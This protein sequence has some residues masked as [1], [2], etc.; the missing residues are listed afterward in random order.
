MRK[1]LDA[2]ENRREIA[3]QPSA[4][5]QPRQAKCPAAT[6]ATVSGARI[7]RDNWEVRK[8]DADPA[9]VRGDEPATATVDAV[10]GKARAKKILKPGNQPENSY[11]TDAAMR[12]VRSTMIGP[13]SC[14]E[15]M[16]R[17]GSAVLV[18]G[19]AF[20]K[21][22]TLLVA[23]GTS[24][25]SARLAIDDI[26]KAYKKAAGNEPVLLA[27]TS[28]IIR[29]KLAKE[30][31]PVL[32][33]NAAMNE[34]AAQG[35]TDLKIQ[36]LHIAPAEE[37]NQLE[38]MVV[39]NIT[40]N[41]GVFKTVKVGYP[42]L[43]SEKDLDAV[44]KVVLASLPKDRKPGDAVVLMGHGNDRGPGDLT[45]A[46]TAAAFHKADPHVWLATVE[47][48]N[49]FDNVLPKLKASGAKRVWLQP[50]MIVAGDHANNDLAGPE[51][52]SWASRIKAAG[53]TPMPNLK[54]LGQLKG[55][56]DIFL[57]HTQNAVVDLANTKKAD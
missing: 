2:P 18:A 31:K 17:H 48:S 22:G 30:G 32:S 12:S 7:F 53:M 14:H 11:G 27:F 51:E 19:T 1:R 26:E 5:N 54:G 55:I 38:R 24:M 34:L 40:K 29:N 56:Q 39:K 3:R 49:S 45:L 37:Y 20:A 9:T 16:F 6:N 15:K 8:N 25:D 46:A 13:R 28:D 23:F 44:V 47:G 43:V 50:F 52:D 21:T 36:S 4:K 57:S 41:P 33:V 42:L 10:Y 35:V